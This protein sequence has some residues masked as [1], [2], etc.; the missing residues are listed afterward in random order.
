[1]TDRLFMH[2]NNIANKTLY[3]IY[4]Y[5]LILPLNMQD[6]NGHCLKILYI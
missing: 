4:S 1:M 3:S 5:C 2:K 6:N